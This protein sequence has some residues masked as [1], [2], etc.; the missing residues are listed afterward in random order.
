MRLERRNVV[1]QSCEKPVTLTSNL[2]DRI[3]TLLREQ[4]RA[5]GIPVVVNIHDVDLARRFS[6][7]IVGMSGGH[8]V[9]DGDG[10]GLTEPILKQIYGGEDWLQ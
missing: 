1:C 2:A 10:A 3:M 5:R 6:D 8:V 7:R 4:G 9:Y